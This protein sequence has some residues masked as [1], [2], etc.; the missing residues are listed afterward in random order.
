MHTITEADLLDRI[1]AFL[2]RHAMAPSAFGRQATGEPQL[3]ASLEGGR[4]PSL[5]VTNR[6]LAF[7]A[8]ADARADLQA[9][10]HP[11]AD[12]DP[13][14]PSEEAELPFVPAPVNPTG[15]SS[16]TSSPTPER[17]TR[18]AAN[19]SCPSCSAEVTAK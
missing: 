14:G 7:M 18:S 19:G 8:D 13:H 17:P 3:V 6:V 5:R 2:E 9:K 10:L 11:P 16:P 1:R 12:A 15:A 4:S